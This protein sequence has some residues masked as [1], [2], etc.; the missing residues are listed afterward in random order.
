MP[1]IL[2]GQFRRG[3][4]L[5]DDEGDALGGG[6]LAG[7]EVGDGHAVAEDHQVRPQRLQAALGVGGVLE[8]ALHVKGGLVVEP[9]VAD[10]GLLLEA[11]GGVI[12]TALDAGDG[13]AAG[14]QRAQQDVVVLGHPAPLAVVGVPDDVRLPVGHAGDDRTHTPSL[15][16]PWR[17]PAGG[18]GSATAFSGGRTRGPA[19]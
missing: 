14:G 13:V 9:A 19:G 8:H 15:A 7:G 16:S 5:D 10:A 17:D 11:D 12:G 2:L 6:D 3:Q 1:G 4:P 18:T